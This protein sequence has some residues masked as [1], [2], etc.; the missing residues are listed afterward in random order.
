MVRGDSGLIRQWAGAFALCA[1]C[2]ACGEDDEDFVV[3]EGEQTEGFCEASCTRDLQC[4]GDGPLDVCTSYCEELVT[5]LE[6]LRADAVQIAGEC[7]M[8]LPCSQFYDPDAFVPC[9][10]RAEQKLEPSGATRRFC[11]AW[12]TR[13]F[14]CGSSYSIEECEADWVTRSASYLERMSACIERSCELLA[15]CVDDVAAGGSG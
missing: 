6:D 14:E 9:W 10:E 3:R 13:W 15:A 11:R 12:S 2:V 7:I 1:A 4:G 8:D 5:G